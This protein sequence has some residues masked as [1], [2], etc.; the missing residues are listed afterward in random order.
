MTY[1]PQVGIRSGSNFA[2]VDVSGSLHSSV[3]QNVVSDPNNTSVL[4]LDTGNSY[5]YT[6][7]GSSTLGVVGL[8]WSLKTDQNAT[9]YVEESPDG[10]N[11]D[12]SYPFNYIASLGGRGETVQATQAFWRL[13]VVLTGTTD[14][15][16]FRLEGVL[17]PIATPLPSSLSSD[18]RLKTETTITGQQN[19]SRH[20][21]VSPTNTL[22]INESSRLVGTNFDGTTK[23][24]NF[25]TESGSAGGT[26]VQTGEIKLLTN[27]TA[28][29]T[30]K[31]TSVRRARFVVGSA[32]LF[33]GAFK[34][35]DT[36]TE[37]NNVRRCGAYDANNG[38]FFELD[39]SRFSVGT[40]K[41]DGT[42]TLVST[43]DF[44][45]NLGT[46]FTPSSN[47]YYKLDIEYTPLGAFYFVNGTLLHQSVGGHLTRF[48]TLPITIENINNN[49]NTT[50][51]TFDC[52]GV[53]ITREG[54][55]VTNPAYAHITAATTHLLKVG[56]GSLHRIIIND[57][58]P[59]ITMTVYDNIAATGDIIAI[60]VLGAK[61]TAPVP[62]EYGL[63][64]SNGLTVV[65]D[66]L[67]DITI[68]YE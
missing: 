30:A 14:T 62:L 3:V 68:V 39:S 40:R 52:L 1:L 31:Y 33:T 24:T 43:G 34:F 48:L 2:I 25:W 18:S 6:G 38:Y 35:N 9:V 4:N 32:L 23:D 66:T 61:A 67:S 64:F 26:I 16:Y 51:V 21:W 41:E 17:C 37:A 65:L 13:R 5:T 44:N 29:G 19:T 36:I 53:A 50:A 10:T 59:Q 42:T 28:N 56:A 12:I 8:Q 45:G 55:L 63:P 49:D 57:P 7:T 22:N 20:T 47:V 27:T 46:T 15:T 60:I 11:W 58:L 54:Q